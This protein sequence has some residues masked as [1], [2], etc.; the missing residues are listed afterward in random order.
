MGKCPTPLALPNK[1]MAGKKRINCQYKSKECCDG[2]KK[3]SLY[4]LKN[5]L[6]HTCRAS[7]LNNPVSILEWKVSVNDDF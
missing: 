2:Q 3:D 4:I 6:S 5:R 1:W 7:Y